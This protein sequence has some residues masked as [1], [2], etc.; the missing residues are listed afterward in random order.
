M[1]WVILWSFPQVPVLGEQESPHSGQDHEPCMCVDTE[2]HVPCGDWYCEA[3]LKSLFLENKSHHIPVKI[4][5]HARVLVLECVSHVV[6]DTPKFVVHRPISAEN[7][8]HRMLAKMGWKEGSGLG[9]DSAGRAE[10]VRTFFCCCYFLYQF[11]IRYILP[12]ISS[13]LW[14]L[15][16]TR[17]IKVCTVRI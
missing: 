14:C 1:W 8:G 5:S 15:N 3:F 12:L 10:P 6:T 9:K 16:G 13:K 2:M 4:I 17:G 7:K 11:F